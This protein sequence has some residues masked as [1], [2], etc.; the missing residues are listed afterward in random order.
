MGEMTREEIAETFEE[1]VANRVPYYGEY[2][3]EGE[4]GEYELNEKYLGTPPAAD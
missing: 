1:V 4:D 2:L 3:I